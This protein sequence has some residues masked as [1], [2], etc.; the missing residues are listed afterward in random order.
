MRRETPVSNRNLKKCSTAKGD[1][2]KVRNKFHND[3][4]KFEAT[5]DIQTSI[6]IRYTALS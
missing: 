5:V 1:H 4:V 6:P 2:G 3:D